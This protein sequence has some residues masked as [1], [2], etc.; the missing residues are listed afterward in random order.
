[1][2]RRSKGLT[3]VNM[4]PMRTNFTMDRKEAIAWLVAGGG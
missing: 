4:Q 1:M 3:P 2:P